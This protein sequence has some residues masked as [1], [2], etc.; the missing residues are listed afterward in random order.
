M[1]LFF[2]VDDP[3]S[4][5]N[6]NGRTRLAVHDALSIRLQFAGQFDI[7][8]WRHGFIA[9]TFDHN[10]FLIV[11]RCIDPIDGF[12]KHQFVKRIFLTL[13]N[14][15]GERRC[16]SRYEHKSPYRDDRIR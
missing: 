4:F 3:G 10:P 13:K 7:S 5:K 1:P 11:L 12:I 15:V 2:L 8:R 16:I 14:A 9:A 6:R